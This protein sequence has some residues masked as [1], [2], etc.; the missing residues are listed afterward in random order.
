MVELV[1]T[2]LFIFTVI[3]KLRVNC[4]EWVGRK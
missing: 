2:V 4:K 1:N 3:R